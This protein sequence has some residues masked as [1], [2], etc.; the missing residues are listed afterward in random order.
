[1]GLLLLLSANLATAF[2]PFGWIR[3]QVAGIWE[4]LFHAGE[5]RLDVADTTMSQA[6][7]TT[8]HEVPA[9]APTTTTTQ[10]NPHIEALDAGIRGQAINSTL[11]ATITFS[12][13]INLVCPSKDEIIIDWPARPYDFDGG[14][15]ASIGK[16][17][18]VVEFIN[19]LHSIAADCRGLIPGNIEGWHMQKQEIIDYLGEIPILEEQNEDGMLM[20]HSLDML[21][22]F[23][24]CPERSS[25]D[26]DIPVDPEGRVHTIVLE[27]MIEAVNKTCVRSGMLNHDMVCLCEDIAGYINGRDYLPEQH[28]QSIVHKMESHKPNMDIPYNGSLPTYQNILHLNNTWHTTYNPD[29]IECNPN[30]QMPLKDFN[31]DSPKLIL[32]HT[33]TTTMPL[34]TLPEK[35]TR[36]TFQT[37]TSTTLKPAL[38]PP[39]RAS[40]TTL[41]TF[42]RR[43]R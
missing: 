35:M 41:K 4:G 3:E 1:V 19:A 28:K 11:A 42:V 9:T 26:L 17:D 5:G 8:L 23:R 25:G 39:L 20:E 40:T 34:K 27:S 43:D 32:S 6:A 24:T 14:D 33:T 31:A 16:E 22:V 2:N 21:P 36:I 12:G 37:T 15:C 10:D 18:E 30:F 38:T 7:S 13:P 29:R